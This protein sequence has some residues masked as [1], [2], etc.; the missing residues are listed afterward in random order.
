VNWFNVFAIYRGLHALARRALLLLAALVVATA[1]CGW[2]GYRQGDHPPQ[3]STVLFRIVSLFGLNGDGTQQDVNPWLNVA[4]WLGCC[5]WAWAIAAVV[6]RLFHQ[7]LVRVLVGGPWCRGHIIV[8][9]LGPD[10]DRLVEQ[11]CARGHKVVVIE[12]EL[13]QPMVEAC[14]A[15]GAVVLQGE[16]THAADL[17]RAGVLRADHL[18]AL[19]G[20]DRHNVQTVV[21]VYELL[22]QATAGRANAGMTSPA[23]ASP[24][25]CLRCTLQVAEPRLQEALGDHPLSRNLADAA[26]LSVFNR[27]ELAARTMWREATRGVSSGSPRRIVVVGGTSGRRLG[28][29]IIWRAAKD[30]FIEHD[31]AVRRERLEIHLYDRD[32]RLWAEHLPQRVVKWDDVVH[33][34]PHECWPEHYSG[35]D[36]AATGDTSQPQPD[37]VFICL[38]NEELAFAQSQRLRKLLPES[39]PIVVQVQQRGAGLDA[40][41]HAGR[42]HTP[43]VHTVGILD[44]VFDP[45]T[46]ILDRVFSTQTGLSPQEE[47]LAQTLHQDYL[48]LSRRKIAEARTAGRSD[49]AQKLGAKPAFVAWDDLAP[50][51]QESNRELA[52]R[53]SR[54]VDSAP[55]GRTLRL[56]HAPHELINP[57]TCWNLSAEQ[58]EQL[59]E[60]EHANWCAYHVRQGWRHGSTRD[61]SAKIHPDLIPW[62]QLS[63]GMRD[64][65]R[66]IIRRLPYVFAKADYRLIDCADERSIAPP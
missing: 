62:A 48:A 16:P 42:Q 35:D 36:L 64:Y 61:E 34:E 17:A 37:A 24:A 1:I 26:E 63:E 13:D 7:S 19:F 54:L 11:L 50:D 2:F 47:E 46:G 45:R 52:R 51:K 33:V 12:K 15:A 53:L 21:T 23:P 56:V 6:I 14:R 65:D 38:D 22:Q 41:L 43:N 29:C 31:G 8:A 18:L 39:V 59:A 27:Y 25:K 32:A 58:F 44:H 40:L 49:E 9:G 4:R 20:E 60:Q 28:E 57:A 66:N 3:T 10:G 30:W 55:G 5:V